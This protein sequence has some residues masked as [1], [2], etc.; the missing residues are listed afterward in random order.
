MSEMIE[1]KVLESETPMSEQNVQKLAED[2]WQLVATVQW[3][4]KFYWYLYR[5]PTLQ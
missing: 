3:G 1:S 2:G 4:G 5:Q